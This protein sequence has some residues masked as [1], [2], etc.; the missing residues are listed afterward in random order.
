LSGKT[1]AVTRTRKQASELGRL[2]RDAGAEVLEIPTIEINDP[3]SWADV[4]E[5][6]NCIDT[7]SWLAF[8][9]PNS[10]D[11]FINRVLQTSGD[12][13]DLGRLKIAAVGPA[14]TKRVESYHLSVA[15]TPEEHHAE[16]LAKALCV[17]M[18]DGERLLYPRASKGRDLIPSLVRGTGFHVEDVVVY[19]TAKPSKIPQVA[20]DR[21]REGHVNL[22]TFASSSAVRHF[23]DLM[24]DEGLLEVAKAT[25]GASIGPATSDTIREL[26][27]DL[28]VEAPAS[29]I[30]VSGLVSAILDYMSK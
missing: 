29:D 16:C 14:T 17:T 26:G 4:D 24:S 7:F 30:S 8:A 12:I 28:V 25:P 20:L 27:Y 6:I 19:Q 10:V 21:F 9:S 15:L 11:R 1:I 2:L 22:V 3:D 5:Q 23:D 18:G 13:R